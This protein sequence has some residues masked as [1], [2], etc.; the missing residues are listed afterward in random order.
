[1][2]SEYFK[3]PALKIRGKTSFCGGRAAGSGAAGLRGT[4]L[5]GPTWGC[6][7]RSAGPAGLCLPPRAAPARVGA[8]PPRSPRAA[9]FPLRG[10]SVSPNNPRSRSPAACP[11]Q[12]PPPSSLIKRQKVIRLGEHTA[13]GRHLLLLHFITTFLQA[14]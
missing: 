4:R 10:V 8:G 7:A 11:G 12:P 2:K 13:R 14:I 3:T 9:A 6:G 5:R 1:M